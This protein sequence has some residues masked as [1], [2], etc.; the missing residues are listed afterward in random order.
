[1]NIKNDN[2][3]ALTS[4]QQQGSVWSGFPRDLELTPIAKI[5]RVGALGLGLGLVNSASHA[6]TIT[7]NNNGDA[8]VACTLRDAIVSFNMVAAQPGCSPS[9]VFGTNDTIVFN[10]SLA[11]NTITLVPGHLDVLS[12][13]PLEI[14]AST[15]SGI[16]VSGDNSNRVFYVGDSATLSVDNLTVTGGS[17]SND[18]GGFDVGSYAS[19]TV[20]NS[21]LT[22]NYAGRYGGA[23]N[24]G[25]GSE[26]E[27]N[28]TTVSNNTAEQ[29]GGG[30]YING[31]AAIT[32]TDSAITDNVAIS[33]EGGGIWSYGGEFGII[34]LVNSEVSGNV[35]ADQGGGIYVYGSGL[36]LV[37]TK[38][39]GNI[40]GD[41]GG[42]IYIVGYGVSL[43]LDNTQVTGNSS[44][45][46]GGGIYANDTVIF[47]KYSEVKNNSSTLDGGGIFLASSALIPLD[48]TVSQNTA[49][50]E[51]STG[52]GG[53]IHVDSSSIIFAYGNY[54]SS[55]VSSLTVSGNSATGAGGGLY[56]ANNSGDKYTGPFPV[57]NILNNS[58]ISGN[59]SSQAG[60]GIRA[61]SS[62]VIA[63]N[64]STL[65]GNS[66]NSYGGAISADYSTITMLNSTVSGNSAANWGGGFYI[67]GGYTDITNSTIANNTAGYYS[68]FYSWYGSNSVKNSILANGVNTGQ[69]S[70]NDCGGFPT[71]DTATI[72][73][74]GSCGSRTG[75]PKLQP[76]T[77][78]G[79]PT[80]THLLSE[81]SIA[82]NSGDNLT[83][84]DIDQRGETRAL[85][86]AD[87]CDV[88]AVEFLTS[89]IKGFY[90][91]PLPNGKIVVI[92]E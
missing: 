62:S 48:T 27:L 39:S 11:G 7:V 78:N 82:I 75:N 23:I 34:S 42:G 24:L 3:S 73:Q 37:D 8:G 69:Y 6:A 46:K 29:D 55:V 33:D 41:T 59:K 57:P 16:T 44:G 21:T 1:M 4:N 49:G 63:V 83:C 65:S 81:N 10:S 13:S 72:V 2:R 15:V 36:S 76:L 54:S 56:L 84:T 26:L 17:A 14:D 87:S 68:N 77:F 66:A 51:F 18:G 71:V 31:A 19:L 74:D 40:S 61:Q 58:T 67:S 53:G 9:G 91:V 86:I 79:G 90:V 28:N 52:R 60:G 45:G 38:I 92:P 12:T 22:D 85:S 35:S 70:Y 50:G 47:S 20:D 80:Q 64:N 25:Y 89:D 30:I 88:G 43:T 5:L 32:I